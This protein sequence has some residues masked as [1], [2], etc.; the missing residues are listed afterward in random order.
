MARAPELGRV[1]RRL[2]AD[3]GPVAALAFY[4]SAS[5]AAVRR[6]SGDPRW[7]TELRV[8]PDRFARP[9]G[10][11]PPGPDRRP[12]GGGDLGARM[13]RAVRAQPPGPV[14]VVGTDIPDVRPVHVARAFRLLGDHDA[15]FG[16]AADG[17]YWLVGLRRRPATPAIFEGVRWSHPATLA[18][19]LANLPPG[20]RVAF[21]DTLEDIDDGAAYRRWED[22]GRAPSA[23]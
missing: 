12:Q 19:T 4:R 2:A 20:A 8:T 17:G 7:R 14:V 11:W 15:V 18:D 5:A 21:L 22:R 16:P 6:L 1:K 23:R 3:I 13:D 10:P 9:G